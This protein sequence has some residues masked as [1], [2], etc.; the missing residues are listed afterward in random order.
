MEL[1]EIS[2]V[3]GSR[4]P[5][6]VEAQVERRERRGSGQHAGAGQTSADSHSCADSTQP[7][8]KDTGEG[9]WGGGG[10]GENANGRAWAQKYAARELRRTRKQ[11]TK[12]VRLRSQMSARAPERRERARACAPKSACKRERR[13]GRYGVGRGEQGRDGDG[14]EKSTKLHSDNI[15][16]VRCYIRT[17]MYARRHIKHPLHTILQHS[18]TFQRST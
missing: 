16:D 2:D 9:K 18:I 17:C 10:G 6:L 14:R 13:G 12:R 11:I 1:D 4:L 5:D 8:N 3:L 7:R 15:T